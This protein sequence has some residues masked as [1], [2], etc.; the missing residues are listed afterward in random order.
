M[1]KLLNLPLRIV[2]AAALP[3]ALGGCA[4]LPAQGSAAAAVAPADSVPLRPDLESRGVRRFVFAGWDGPVIPVWYYRPPGV[5]PAAPP[6]FVMHGVGRD[7]D[8]YLA[9]WLDIARTERLLVVVPEFTRSGF[10]GAA[11]YN[12]GGVFDDQGRP[13]PRRL[14]AYSAIEPLF[15][16][17]RRRE[18]LKARR[19]GLY[20]HSAGAQFVHRFVL[21]GSGLR[22]SRAV[23][24]NAG[25]YMLPT[26]AEKWPFGLSGA[27][28]GA[29]NP[30][31]AFAAPLT[32]LLGGADNDPAHQS[33]PR[34][35]EAVRQGP[36]RLARGLAFHSAARAEAK[37]L[38]T[39]FAWS[40]AIVPG[41]GH[42][43]GRMTAF[44]APLFSGR[45]PPGL[46]PCPG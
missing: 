39:G 27:P 10:P 20:G 18:G 25:S 3:G 21:L 15:D 45:R 1:P 23:S 17:I 22:M 36:H 28:A 5:D 12:F 31:R 26:R 6:L 13:R 16:A 42:D 35:P 2:L 29:W 4:A 44:A 24:A 30:R 8:R 41:V 37:R 11:G 40:C 19:Y 38:A 46:Q 34:Q 9:E 33:L 43:N 14:W 7:A 32:L